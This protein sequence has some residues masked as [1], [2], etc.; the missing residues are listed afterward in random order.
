M[1]VTLSSI[2]VDDQ[3]K[4]LDFYAG[5]LGFVVRDNI[6]L[7]DGGLAWLTLASPE[8]PDGARISLE[9]AGF[10]W[11]VDFQR[12]MKAQGVPLTAFAVADLDREYERLVAAGVAFRGAPAGG[13]AAM[14]RTATFDDTCGNWIMLYEEPA[15]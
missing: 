6:P 4:A 5:T 2:I 13:D 12:A 15:P 10:A 1:R 8:D 14:P 3:K 7:G 9:P 11:A